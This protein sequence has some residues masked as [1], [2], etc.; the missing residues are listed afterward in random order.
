MDLSGIKTN[1]FLRLHSFLEAL[2]NLFSCAFL[3]SKGHILFL[4]PPFF[5]FKASKDKLSHTM[6]HFH[7]YFS[8]LFLSSAALFYFYEP[9]GII[10]D[11]LSI[12]SSVD[13]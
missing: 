12:L 9:I 6:H 1:V 10:N 5:I 4:Q 2:E 3:V 11:N 7:S 13:L 8:L